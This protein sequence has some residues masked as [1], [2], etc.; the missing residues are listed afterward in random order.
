M[1]APDSEPNNSVANAEGS[2]GS[3]G[4]KKS[5]GSGQ[6]EPSEG[7]AAAGPTSEHA[8]SP[9]KDQLCIRDVLGGSPD[10]FEELV[11]RYQRAVFGVVLS[12]VR[13]VHRAE[14]L[15]QE[16]FAKAFSNLKQLRA[17]ERFF[18]WLLQIARHRASREIRRM[19]ARPE[20][21]LL[22]EAE[23]PAPDENLDVERAARILAM[24]EELP[25]PYRETV[26]L[27]YQQGMSCREIAAKESV[28]IGTITS[29]LTRAL[30]VLR[31]A[32]GGDKRKL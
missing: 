25:D 13:D 28:A 15:S 26:L 12:Y 11:T 18:P 16:V 32:L 3:K 30:A 22:P 17:T 2:K 7:P 10:R 24:V 5:D 4:S 19:A 1:V 31:S 9:E 27:K 23:P 6:A 29:R 14:D 8:A 21:Q 20:T